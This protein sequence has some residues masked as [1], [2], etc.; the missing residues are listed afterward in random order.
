MNKRKIQHL[1]GR[2]KIFM[3]TKIHV[4]VICRIHLK[5]KIKKK[6]L[7]NKPECVKNFNNSQPF[8]FK[9]QRL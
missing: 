9:Q 7:S 6:Y 1:N 5:K 2:P 8:W 3:Q 4:K